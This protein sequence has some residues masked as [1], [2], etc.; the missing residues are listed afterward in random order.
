MDSLIDSKVGSRR[1]PPVRVAAALLACA[2]A[3]CVLVL[4]SLA[5]AATFDPLNVISDETLRAYGSM[6][7]ADIQAFLEAQGGVLKS[8]SAAEGGPNGLHSAVVKP[9]SQII[10]EAAQYWNVNPKLVLATLEKEQSLIS[11]PFHVGRDTDPASSHN[12][13]TAYHLTNAMGAGVYPGSP[14]RHPGFG[15]QIWTGTQKLGQTTGPYAWYPGKPKT[16]WSYPAHANIVITVANQPTWNLYTYTPYYPQISVWT[17]YNNFFGDPQ[18]PPRLRPMYRFY[19]K[20]TGAFFFT[21]SEA[22]RW[23]VIKSRNPDLRFQGV[24][25]SIDTSSTAN[26]SPLYRL[27]NKLGQRY[28][29]TASLSELRAALAIRKGRVRVYRLDAV[30]AYVSTDPASGPPVYRLYCR[31]SNSYLYTSSADERAALLR[32]GLWKSTGVAFYLGQYVE[33]PAPPAPPPSTPSSP[34]TPPAG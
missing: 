21:V 33:P 30:S 28:Y 8:Y 15:D 20:R 23:R 7:Q 27:Y 13:G 4:P 32:S 9:A 26:S 14:D 24:G 11:Q 31:R 16:V 1:R 12:Y 29:Y 2:L 34:T 18:T 6:S 22:E 5:A 3:A 10:F 25:F 19:N 17:I